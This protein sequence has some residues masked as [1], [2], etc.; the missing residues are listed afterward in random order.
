MELSP[1]TR[2]ASTES[3]VPMINVVF[4]LLI[5]FL[6]TSQIAP[7]DPFDVTTP[8][9]RDGAEPEARAVLYASS[10]GRLHYDGAEDAAALNRLQSVGSEDTTVL[11]RADAALEATRLAEIL[12]DLA[13]SG[14][15]R[16]ELVVQPQ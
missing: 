16:V 4:L 11:L 13:Q 2:K 1:P 9:A 7:P 6:M 5:F 14:L 10:T 12:S 3:I 15:T 8:I